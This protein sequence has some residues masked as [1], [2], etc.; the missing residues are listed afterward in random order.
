MRLSLPPGPLGQHPCKGTY[1]GVFTGSNQEYID[2][3]Y[4]QHRAGGAFI[5]RE[6]IDHIGREQIPGGLNSRYR[7]TGGVDDL[8][9]K[10]LGGWGQ[11]YV[12]GGAQAP[13]GRIRGPVEGL[14]TGVGLFAALHPGTWGW[15]LDSG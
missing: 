14:P 9:G 6:W 4:A 15:L 2:H 8:E 12:R 10:V 7:T 5:L 11:N 1:W 3:L 13:A